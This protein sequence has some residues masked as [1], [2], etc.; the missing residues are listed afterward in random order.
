ML[1]ILLL[2]IFICLGELE[3]YIVAFADLFEPSAGK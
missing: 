3:V 1:V 2:V